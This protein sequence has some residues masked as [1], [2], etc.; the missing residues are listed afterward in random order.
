MSDAPIKAP[1]T[2]KMNIEN[3]TKLNGCFHILFHS[4]VFIVIEILDSQQSEEYSLI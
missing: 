1:T 3:L 4:V 2:T